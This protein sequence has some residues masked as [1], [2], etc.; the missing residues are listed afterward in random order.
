MVLSAKTLFHFTSFQN[1]KKILDCKYFQVNYS[2]EQFAFRQ[3]S[4]IYYVPMVCL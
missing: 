2:K 3:S 1:L 4:I